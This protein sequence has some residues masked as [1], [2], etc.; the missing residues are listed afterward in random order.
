MVTHIDFC[1]SHDASD[2]DLII[3][4]EIEQ[5]RNQKPLVPVQTANTETKN[6][7]SKDVTSKEV[8]QDGARGAVAAAAGKLPRGA[9]S[10]EAGAAG[11]Q[12]SQLAAGQELV[13]SPVAKEE[14]LLLRFKVGRQ[15]L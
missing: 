12:A 4:S 15:V 11:L 8:G 5:E 9:A 6:N 10:Q 14:E 13:P 3:A 2:L 1:L 7:R